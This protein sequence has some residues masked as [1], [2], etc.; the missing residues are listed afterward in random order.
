RMPASQL[1]GMTGYAPR[2]IIHRPPPRNSATRHETSIHRLSSF[3]G[4]LDFSSGRGW[5][6]GL[7]CLAS[8]RK[9]QPRPD[10]RRAIDLRIVIKRRRDRL[11][12]LF[13]EAAWARSS[14]RER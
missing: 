3:Y 9:E 1:D 8:L 5:S 10:P 4:C 11:G 14:K 2:H 7:A 12:L 13:F 6:A